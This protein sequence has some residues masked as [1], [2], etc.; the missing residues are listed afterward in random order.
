MPEILKINALEKRFGNQQALDRVSFSVL[1]GEIFG[2]LGPNGAGKSTLMKILSGGLKQD[3]GTVFFNGTKKEI[4]LVPQE[5]AFFE[6]FTV[7]E[8]LEF[9]AAELNIP[10]ASLEIQEILSRFELQKMARRPAKNL[11]GGYKRLLNL[12]I[13]L[14]Q[15]PRLLFLDEP[16]VGL[17]PINRTQLWE[18][19]RE[20]REKGATICVSTHYMEEA[21]SLCDRIC[22]ISRGK[23][24]SVDSPENLVSQFA[25][26]H[27]TTITL[28]RIPGQSLVQALSKKFLASEIRFQGPVIAL[29]LPANSLE[30]TQ[31][32]KAIIQ[33]NGFE[34]LKTRTKEPDLEQ[35]FI[36]ATGQ[37][38]KES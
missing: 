24:V 27:L 36:N 34:I 22:L 10:N 30:K 25:P 29:S 32:A 19:I 26:T 4:A 37:E 15:K 13:S 35:A 16:T 5:F 18:K 6:E 11:S 28:S 8:N 7:L 21:S 33:S 9:F 14:L 2:L 12:S 1:E 31:T 38:L 17:D 23:T 20:T 3:N